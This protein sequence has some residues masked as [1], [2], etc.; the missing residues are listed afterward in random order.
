MRRRSAYPGY[1][2]DPF[3]DLLFNALLGF[4]FLFLIA[5]VFMNPQHQREGAKLKAEYI[6]TINWPET[7]TDDIDLWVQDPTGEVVS[8]LQRE[9]AWMHLDRDDRGD[10]ND[11]VIIEGK[12]IIHPLNQ[13]I[14]TLRGF[15]PGEYVVNIYYYEDRS[16]GE[17]VP[18]SVKIER[19][20]P[21]F[22]LVY[23]NQLE[24]KQV[25]DE[26]T[27]T[28]FTLKNDGELADLNQLPVRLTPYNLEPS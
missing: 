7:R 12:E 24:L 25:D 14:V 9:V 13:E 5:I 21:V 16:P 18:V 23:V 22:K 6:I 4:T 20:N 2:T 8:Y 27:A 15:V 17:S 28:R 26:L 3:T 19:V 10:I 11:K 1:S